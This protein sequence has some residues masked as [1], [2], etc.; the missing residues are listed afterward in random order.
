MAFGFS[1][2]ST[3]TACAETL[4]NCVPNQVKRLFLY[5][6]PVC[7]MEATCENYCGQINAPP[8]I[9]NLLLSL[10]AFAYVSTNVTLEGKVRSFNNK[11]VEVVSE[12][13]V[14]KIP[15]DKLMFADLKKDQ[16]SLHKGDL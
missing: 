9:F 8:M 15:R 12:N 16:I 2:R 5:F 14:Y 10:S 13:K 4:K 3:A 11:E 6:T 7:V 1:E